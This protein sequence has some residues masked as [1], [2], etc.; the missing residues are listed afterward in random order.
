VAILGVQ[1]GSSTNRQFRPMIFRSKITSTIGLVTFLSLSVLSPFPARTQNARDTVSELT[2]I[3]PDI[4]FRRVVSSPA[5]T[6]SNDLQRIRQIMAAYEEYDRATAE[7]VRLHPRHGRIILRRAGLL[8]TLGRDTEALAFLAPWLED[9]ERTVAADHEFGRWLINEAAFAYA[10]LGQYDQAVELMARLTRLRQPR[11]GDAI[12][13]QINYAALLFD[14]REPAAALAQIDSIIR[15]LRA[16]ASP[17]AW[18]WM[19]STQACAFVSLQQ[20]ARALEVIE[21]MERYR[22]A[23]GAPLMRALLCANQLDRAEALLLDRL[24]SR[25]RDWLLLALQDYQLTKS[26]RGLE[27]VIH[28]RFLRLRDRPSVRAAIERV[29]VI[30][31][32]PLARTYYGAMY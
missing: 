29:G 16:G 21:S 27:A 17:G 22:G 11:F 6:G 28:E 13:T 30:L 4:T 24:R 14:A 5:G 26:S 12:G 15:D 7:A 3:H 20:N 8:R 25:D 2:A 18:M 10:A 32:L 31:R 19:A 1:A 23:G 9:V